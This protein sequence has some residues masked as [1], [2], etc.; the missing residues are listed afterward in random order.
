MMGE[1]VEFSDKGVLEFMTPRPDVVAIRADS[2]VEQLRKLLIETKF[3]R[4]PVY[5]HSLD[6]VTSVAFARDLLQVPDD[7]ARRRTARELARPAL[8]VPETKRGSY[9]LKEM[10]RR[11]N[12]IAIVLDE[13]GSVAGILTV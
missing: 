4:V 10:Q 12:Q 11:D 9:L 1:V 8:F 6:D 5:E 7:E 3:S 13:H 2:T